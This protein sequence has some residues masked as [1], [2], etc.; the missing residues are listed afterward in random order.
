MYSLLLVPS[1]DKEEEFKSLNTGNPFTEDSNFESYFINRM[2]AIMEIASV[3]SALHD[4]FILK[5]I[6]V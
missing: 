5:G 4:C 6:S 1:K 2:L 3:S